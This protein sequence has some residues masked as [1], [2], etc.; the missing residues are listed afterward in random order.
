VGFAAALA[1]RVP[2]RAP[3]LA[4]RCGL[5][6]AVAEAVRARD[7]AE[8]ALSPCPA[9]RVAGAEPGRRAAPVRPRL[10]VTER[11]FDPDRGVDALV[12]GGVEDGAEAAWDGEFE[13]PCRDE[14]D[15]ELGGSAGGLTGRIGTVGVVTDGVLTVGIVMLGVLTCGVVIG[16]AVTDGT[17]AVETVTDGTETVG[18]DTA[19]TDSVRTAAEAVGTSP[20]RTGV[21]ATDS[22]PHTAR[23]VR[24]HRL[25]DWTTAPLRLS[26]KPLT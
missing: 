18:R 3:P 9:V 15:V 20:A 2:E 19:G 12:A 24:R 1:K 25:T 13:E 7:A 16:P 21:T 26:R 4:V 11:P 5:D 23:T 6:A 22:A 17:V 10:P 14:D 8:V